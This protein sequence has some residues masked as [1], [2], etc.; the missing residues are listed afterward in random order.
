MNQA[1][2]NPENTIFAAQRAKD[3]QK[4]AT[5]EARNRLQK[6]CFTTRKTLHDG[7][8]DEIEKAVQETL[9]LLDQNHLSKKDEFE[10]KQKEF[11]GVVNAIKAYQLLEMEEKLKAQQNQVE[12]LQ[13]QLKEAQS[14]RAW[15]LIAQ[16]PSAS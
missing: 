9:D 4:R 10:A 5:H 3:A 11:E 16:L 15:L 2:N 8:K 13:C 12:Q 1:S 6:C 14:Q 7:R